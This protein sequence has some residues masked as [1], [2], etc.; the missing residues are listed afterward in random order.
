MSIPYLPA[1]LS[2]LA[3]SVPVLITTY[4]NNKTVRKVKQMDAHNQIVIANYNKFHEHYV[5]YVESVFNYAYDPNT[6]NQIVYRKS[7]AILL[8]YSSIF[9]LNALDQIDTLLCNEKFDNALAMLTDLSQSIS[10]MGEH[11]EVS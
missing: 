5:D 7:L 3:A 8:S 4:L 1:I 10:I 2:A 6:D 9:H 11:Q